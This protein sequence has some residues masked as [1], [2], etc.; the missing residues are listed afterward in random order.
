MSDKPHYPGNSIMVRPD[1]PLICHSDT[2]VIIRDADGNIIRQDRE[3][4]LCRC[5]ASGNKPFC[6]G[7]HK[8]AGFQGEQEFTDDRAEDITGQEG[9]LVIT[10]KQNAMLSIN[11]PVTIF[12]RSGD[13]VTTRTRG[14]LCRCGQSNKKPFCDVSHKQTGFKG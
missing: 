9:D 3:I 2:A 8:A 4:A 11:G 1:G 7:S 10:V 12:S 6:D 14:A 13:S 5:G